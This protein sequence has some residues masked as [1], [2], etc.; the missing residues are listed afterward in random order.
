[1]HLEFEERVRYRSRS[2]KPHSAL[3]FQGTPTDI[4]CSSVALET[5][6]VD[7]E[8]VVTA[9][10]PLDAA[11]AEPQTGRY[12]QQE[13]VDSI[14][15][16]LGARWSDVEA[17]MA[18]NIGDA[19]KKARKQASK[20][21]WRTLKTGEPAASNFPHTALVRPS[22]SLSAPIAIYAH[23]PIFRTQ[24]PIHGESMD[25][26]NPC[27]KTFDAK[28]KGTPPKSCL[29]FF[30]SISTAGFNQGSGRASNQP[31]AGARKRY[32]STKTFAQRA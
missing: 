16:A 23:Y 10:Q 20:E 26:T 6:V 17:L 21:A 9:D 14:K 8:D 31:R 24:K 4:P 18:A 32:T 28:L 5:L 7:A 15:L 29:F 13:L 22:G 11:R 19:D 1:M 30:L 12:S 3:S 25:K 2:S 27:M